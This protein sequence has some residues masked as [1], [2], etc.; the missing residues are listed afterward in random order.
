MRYH[1]R[2]GQ[3]V[4]QMEGFNQPGSLP[5]RYHNPGD[6]RHGPHVSHTGL[7]P[8]AV[9]QEPSDELGEQD[10]ERQFHLDA[11]RGWTLRDFVYSYAP[12]CENNSSGYLNFICAGLKLHPETSLTYALTIPPQGPNDPGPK[13]S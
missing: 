1:S 2:L 5:Q 9:G 10:M 12:P 7:S 13:A 6:L 8:N 11:S 4:A 3:L